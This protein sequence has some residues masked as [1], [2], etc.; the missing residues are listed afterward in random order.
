V[1]VNLRVYSS[2]KE[3]RRAKFGKHRRYHER[4]GNVAA[5]DVYYGWRVAILKQ[6]EE[7]KRVALEERFWDNRNCSKQSITAKLSIET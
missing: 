3:L 1:W 7:Q 2:R 6:R 5:A 4:T